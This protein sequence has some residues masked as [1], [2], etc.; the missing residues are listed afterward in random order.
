MRIAAQY[1]HL[2]GLEFLMVHKPEL[3]SEIQTI[4]SETDAVG[5]R[6]KISKEKRMLDRILY[7]P[8]AMNKAMAGEFSG[9]GWKDRRTQYWVTPVSF[10]RPCICRRQS[11][12]ATLKRPD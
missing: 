5:C 7:S 1:T 2:N 4:I 11:R 12:N 6:T 3:W 9:R 10:A 8:D